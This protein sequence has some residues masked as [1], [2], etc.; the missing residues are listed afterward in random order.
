MTR[1]LVGRIVQVCILCC[2]F[3]IIPSSALAQKNDTGKEIAKGLLRALIESQMERQERENFAPGRHELPP[4]VQPGQ[5]TPEMQQVR[6][7]LTAMSQESANL[8]A[9]VS[10][11]ARNN[12][13]LRGLQPD[14]FRFQA[15]TAATQQ[16]ADRETNHFALQFAVQSL[17]Q[18]W[19]PLAHRLTSIAG[20]SPPTRDCAGRLS[21]LNGQVCQILGIAE[22]FNSR[23]L[24]RSADLL[25]ADLKT[26]RDD[27]S[28]ASTTTV[29]RQKLIPRLQRHQEQAGLFA[30]LAASGAQFN[31]VVAEYRALYQAWQTLRPEIDT[32]TGRSI[33]RTVGRIQETHRSIHQLLR[34]EFGPDFGMVQRMTETL[35]K[36]LTDLSRVITLEQIMLL[37][38]SRSLPSSVDAL[39]G[40]AQNLS[41]VVSR[42]ESL[43]AAGEAWVFLDQQW[44]L[45]A[46]YL[47]PVHTPE[48]CRRIEGITQSI[49]AL[50]DAMGIVVSFDRR[51]I[52]QEAATMTSLVES[53]HDAVHR[54][55]S[56]PG[57][58]AEGLIEKT[59]E[60]EDRCGELASM[61][62]GRSDRSAM[63][64]K[65]E[66]VLVVW[67]QI[68]PQLNACRTDERP[69][70]DQIADD[71]V[72]AMIRLQ[73]M[74][75]E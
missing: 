16:R 43:Q 45:V 5:S 57:Q 38:D 9:L 37:P 8:S 10:T 6:R 58:K 51:A 63:I 72:Q 2:G 74:L 39:F 55:V 42:R 25:A 48:T 32:F 54:W 47:E 71:F 30:N 56:R 29:V 19:K 65:S 1:L 75:E 73:A 52:Q 12:L 7:L 60:L 67:Q 15:A 36:D 61:A 14:I 66:Q 24:V 49:A 3:G 68:R 34:L 41:D 62:S 20:I 35:E 23:D 50:K 33:T 70:L 28:Y 18:T 64:G 27:V 26:L 53:L 13:E 46:Y 40:M 59:H 11:D 4:A 44:S 31:S 21:R 22:Q 69:S 17:D